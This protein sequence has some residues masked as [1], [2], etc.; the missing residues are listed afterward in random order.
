V[1]RVLLVRV[2][3]GSHL[4]GLA[5]SVV[6]VDTTR[7]TCGRDLVS[8]RY[9]DVNSGKEGHARPPPFSDLRPSPPI[10]LG[11][12]RTI[13]DS[14]YP[15]PCH[16]AG[17]TTQTAAHHTAEV[18]LPWWWYCPYC[19]RVLTVSYV[20]VPR[21]QQHG[22][23]RTPMTQKLPRRTSMTRGASP[24]R[25]VSPGKGRVQV[26]VRVRPLIGAES[27]RMAVTNDDTSCSLVSTYS[28]APW[29]ARGTWRV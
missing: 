26:K 9:D 10:E 8:P 1:L 5:I 27:G 12:R 19:T 20:D 13:C 25:A 4:R 14:K 28:R 11:R 24:S 23:A 17:L 21:R 7:L 16:D 22:L 3:Q 2:Q 18:R 6:V 15:T 29:V